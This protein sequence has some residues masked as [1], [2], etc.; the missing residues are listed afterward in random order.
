MIS[1]FPGAGDVRFSLRNTTY[2]NNSC[3]TLEDIGEGNDALLCVT[4]LT[5]CCKPPYIGNG[6]ASGNWFF[7]NKS[8]IP[9][10]SSQWEFYRDRGK[11]VVRMWTAEEVEWRGSTAVRYVIQGMLTRPYTLECTQQAVVSL[12]CTDCAWSYLVHQACIKLCQ[13]TIFLWSDTTATTRGRHLLCWEA[14][15]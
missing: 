11:M 1:F 14:G 4:N 5:A 15:R 3:V 9:G 12:L 6:S 7:P 13:H 2:Q 10:H 8:R